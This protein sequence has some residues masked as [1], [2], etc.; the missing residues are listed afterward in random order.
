MLI[1]LPALV[2]LL[3]VSTA[4]GQSA[5]EQ[6][7]RPLLPPMEPAESQS[8]SSRQ[9]VFVR[10]FRFEGNTVYADDK[11]AAQ[12][13]DFVER[14]L[15]IEDLEEA[16][17]ALTRLYVEDGYI[18]SGAM[19]P[20]QDVEDG[21]ITF[22]II[23]G[24]LRPED[25]HINSHEKTNK[26]GEKTRPRLRLSE[27]HY[28]MPRIGAGASTVLNVNQ[29][30]DRL[31]LLRQNPNIE[32][33][34]AEL[35]PGTLPGQSE[36]D[37]LLEERNSIH[38]GLELSNKRPPAIGG[39]RLE[40]RLLHDNL[41][42]VSDALN[43]R[44]TI[45]QG[46]IQDLQFAGTEDYSISYSRP[47]NAAETTLTVGFDRSD[48]LQIQEPFVDLNITSETNSGYLS[49]RQAIF[50]TPN[51]ELAIFATLNVQENTTFLLGQPFSFSPGAKNG[52][53]Q[54]SVLR[55][56][57]DF[58]MRDQKQALALRSTFN[59]GLPIFGATENPSG[60][61]DGQFFS[62]LGQAQYVRRLWETDNQL[63][64]R[65][66]IQLA[67][68]PLLSLEQ[69]A[70]GG[71]DTVR[72]YEENQI[73]RDS[74]FDFTVQVDVPVWK[75]STM[76]LQLA[77][78]FDVGSAWNHDTPHNQETLSSV[79]IGVLYHLEKGST[80]VDL[81]IYYGYAFKHFD[82]TDDL[83]GNGITFDLVFWLF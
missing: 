21:I 56:G 40:A 80:L 74:G 34:N 16:R 23:E 14:E 24:Q 58:V 49:I 70:I 77:P 82:S 61:P 78:F 15:T 55:F 33:I 69:F 25:I 5:S 68:N 41:T 1:R 45:L 37:V 31:E 73:V 43:L 35:I 66:N 9:T 29:L 13:R 18:S 59:V 79:G 6:T 30:K 83:Q 42:G 39:S 62:W 17:L 53:S 4:L 26:K 7:T 12:L 75:T 10:G 50:R 32:R 64:L 72:G 52:V 3:A 22:Q 2:V 67:A 60:I 57:P 38:L 47:L 48:S 54:D 44:Y 63:I 65:G 46:D 20:D 51:K 71:F 19:L 28:L 8:L 76:T 27:K 36:L 11:L 81:A